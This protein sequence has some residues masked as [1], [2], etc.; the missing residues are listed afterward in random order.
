LVEPEARG[1]LNANHLIPARPMQNGTLFTEDFLLE[2]IKQTQD[3]KDFA[4]A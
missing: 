1:L 2:G 3:W 4:D